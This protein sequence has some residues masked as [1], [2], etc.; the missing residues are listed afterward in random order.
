MVRIDSPNSTSTWTAAPPTSAPA[1]AC[2]KSFLQRE[3]QEAGRAAG[4]TKPGTC[5]TF[6]QSFATRLLEDGHDIRT[7]QERLDHRDVS[8]TMTYTHVINRGQRG[9]RSP[10]DR[11]SRRGAPYIIALGP[12]C[13]PRQRKDGPTITCGNRLSVIYRTTQPDNAVQDTKR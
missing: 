6:R 3:V 7:V 1:P 5:H 2:T 8:T 13:S 12:R 9:V 11:I 10:A 4:S